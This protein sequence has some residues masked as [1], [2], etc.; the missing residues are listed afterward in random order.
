MKAF[1]IELQKRLKCS[2][3]RRCVPTEWGYPIILITQSSLSVALLWNLI[4]TWGL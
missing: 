1:V 3:E 2:A 4:V